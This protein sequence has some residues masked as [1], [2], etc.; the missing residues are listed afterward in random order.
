MDAK[1]DSERRSVSQE[2]REF[3]RESNAIEDVWDDESLEQSI[4]AWLYIKNQP[5]LNTSNIK[6]THKILMQDKIPALFPHLDPKVADKKYLG[7]Y[8][9]I[10]IFIGGK[11]GL[12]YWVL[13]DAVRYWANTANLPMGWDQIK[14]HHVGYERIHPFVDGNGRTGRIFLN[15]QRVH[16][17][18]PV[19]VIKESTKFVDYYKWFK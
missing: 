14:E 18:L 11:Q 17:S 19:L 7:H 16:N 15:W 4:E 10:P 5:R 3:L 6:K 9:D 1:S 8:R 13:P 12:P 2:E